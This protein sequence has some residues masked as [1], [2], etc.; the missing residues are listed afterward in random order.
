MKLNFFSRIKEGLTR[1]RQQ[2]TS[3]LAN[4]ILGKKTLDP[5]L[6]ENIE[7]QLLLADMGIAVTEKIIKIIT[8]KLSR[9]E[10]TSPE[11]VL[12]CLQT[13]LTE[14][15]QPFAQPL[16]VNTQNKPFVILMVGVN[17]N[18]KTTTIGKLAHQFKAQDHSVLLAG[19]DT[20][21]AA[22][23]Q[24]LQTWGERTQCAVVAQPTGADSASVMFDAIQSARAKN[25]DIVIADTAGRL[26]TQNNLME[27]L[28]KNIRVIKKLDE[29]A[30]HAILLVLDAATGQNALN[31]AREFHQ[32]L[33][34]TGLVIT[35][36]DGTAK[37]GMVFSI[38]ENLKLPI[39]FIGV[40]EG[41]DDLVPFDAQSFVQA[42][43]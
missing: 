24:Q 8:D 28:K 27:E 32:A 7:N 42:I 37:G 40:G 14:V 13:T 38:A 22:A 2:L 9:K 43:I 16:K 12:L 25:I 1:T 19:G 33:G 35:K 17:G 3:G 21:R 18:G 29:T 6:L 5:D 10:L 36:L 20:F 34:L 23:V 41:V 4:L 11:Q 26:H 31:Q 15:L 39:H 30:P